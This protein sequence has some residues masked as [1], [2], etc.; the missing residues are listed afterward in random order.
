M[1]RSILYFMTCLEVSEKPQQTSIR[2]VDAP[3]EIRT[4]ERQ[5]SSFT[6]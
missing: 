2:T 1:G 5:N 6:G 3:V 4:F